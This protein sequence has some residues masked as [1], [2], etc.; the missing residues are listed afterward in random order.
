MRATYETAQHYRIVTTSIF[1]P[2]SPWQPSSA[3]D[4]VPRHRPT[5]VDARFPGPQ[6]SRTKPAG[7]VASPREM[8]T[9]S[10]SHVKMHA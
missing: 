4:E 9:L 2:H 3:S 5:R 1:V 7:V 10:P 6:R 8:A